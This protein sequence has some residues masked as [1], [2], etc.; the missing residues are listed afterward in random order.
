MGVAA[1]ISAWCFW[2]VLTDRV[3]LPSHASSILGAQ[4]ESCARALPPSAAQGDA[5]WKGR[6]PCPAAPH[7]PPVASR[8]PTTGPGLRLGAWG[9]GSYIY[10][11]EL[12]A[13]LPSPHALCG[14]HGNEHKSPSPSQRSLV[15][16]A[17]SIALENKSQ[18]QAP[19]I[20]GS[21]QPISQLI[22]STG[23]GWGPAHASSSGPG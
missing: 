2:H 12:S 8:P 14:F 13:R 11:G 10:K 19:Q 6:D 20:P 9:R 3:P 17:H 16:F 4:T 18:T 15:C 7:L 21:A 1:L 23:P 22:R 5:R